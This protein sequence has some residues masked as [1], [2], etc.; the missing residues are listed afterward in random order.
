MQDDDLLWDGFLFCGYS[1][2]IAFALEV[3]GEVGLE[4]REHVGA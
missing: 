1:E 3:S 2:W 4:S